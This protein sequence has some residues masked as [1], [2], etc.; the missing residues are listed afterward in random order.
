MY[1]NTGYLN[2]VDVDLCDLKQPLTI[3]SCGVYRLIHVPS[4]IINRTEGRKDYQ[5]LYISSGKA[6]FVFD[7]I[8]KEVSEGHMVLYRPGMPQQYGY[9]LEDRP[10]VYWIH[11]TGSDAGE[12]MTENGF[13][14]PI[15]HTGTDAEY[16]QLFLKIIW[17]LQIHRPYFTDLLPLLFRQLLLTVK[18]RRSEGTKEV[19][20]V[21]QEIDRAVLFFHEHFSSQ[22]NIEDYAK[23]QNMS[24]CWF[25]RSFKKHT[26]MAPK[27]FITSIRMSK[28]KDLLENT[29]YNI[30]EIAQ[31]VGYE[32]PLYFSRRFRKDMGE[33]PSKYRGRES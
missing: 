4:M 24:I 19:S 32:N 22:I 9:Y 3:E 5:L 14:E 15:L 23:S 10:E 26:G 33:S 11:F 31:I 16:Q 8:R 12:I 7:G 27:Q 25:I 29:D 18:S 28:A 1:A 6:W 30:T 13:K 21:D 20:A 17:E 2:Q